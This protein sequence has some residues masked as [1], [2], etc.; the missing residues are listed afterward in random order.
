MSTTYLTYLDFIVPN[1]RSNRKQKSLVRSL[2]T[3]CMS[4]SCSLLFVGELILTIRSF[5]AGKISRYIKDEA[6]A[7]K[8]KSSDYYQMAM[9]L[10][11]GKPV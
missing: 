6:H 7:L 2:Y 10:N 4:S 3:L 5:L 11:A 1:F 8:N 9:R